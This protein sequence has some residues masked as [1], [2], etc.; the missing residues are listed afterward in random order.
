MAAAAAAAAVGGA[1]AVTL[2]EA[3]PVASTPRRDGKKAPRHVVD[4][5][6][7]ASTSDKRAS[8]AQSLKKTGEKTKQA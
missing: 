8:V 5:Q 7:K 6:Q 4:R 2:E 1:A 3:A